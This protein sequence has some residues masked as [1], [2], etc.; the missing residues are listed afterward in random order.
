M[1]KTACGYNRVATYVRTLEY[2]RTAVENVTA[3]CTTAK[4]R[5]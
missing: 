3:T 5:S 2:V 1:E 4:R